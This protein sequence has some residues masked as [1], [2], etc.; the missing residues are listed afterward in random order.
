MVSQIGDKN[1]IEATAKKK[2]F[3]VVFL[4]S[5]YPCIFR[6]NHFRDLPT[7]NLML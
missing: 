4:L 5:P 6:T 1:G 2:V 7:M 3:P